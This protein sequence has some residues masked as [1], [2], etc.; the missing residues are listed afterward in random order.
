MD[1]DQH[2]GRQRPA[3]REHRL[4]E[5]ITGDHAFH[6][7]PDEGGPRQGRLLL[8]LLG[9]RVDARLIED[10]LDRVGAGIEPELFQFPRDPLVTPE[11]VFRAN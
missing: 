1:E 9:A 5:E 8:S 4:G 6:M 11:K 10:A 7:R 3:R 2:I